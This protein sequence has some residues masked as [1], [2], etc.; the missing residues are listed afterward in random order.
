MILGANDPVTFPGKYVKSRCVCKTC[1]EGWM[2]GLESGTAPILKP[3]I[4]DSP[5]TL[6]Y[7]QQ[8]ALS[9]WTTKTTMVY[10]CAKEKRKAAFYSPANRQ[11]L[12]TWSTPPPD[13][14]IWI[15]R[16]EDSYSLF[17]ENHYLANPGTANVLSEGCVTTFAMGRLVVQMFSARRGLHGE[18]RGSI[19]VARKE[20]EWDRLLIQIWPVRER[21]IRWPPPLSFGPSEEHLKELA[22]RIGGQ[23]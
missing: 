14:L 4:S 5:C 21:F 17:I 15:G 13:S 1:N 8:L 3:L 2:S 11:H 10:E 22:K 6:D 12:L 20:G 19:N 7:I 23:R 18:G 16:Y 9:V